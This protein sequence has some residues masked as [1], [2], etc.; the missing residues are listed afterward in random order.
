MKLQKRLNRRVAGKDYS[1]WIVTIPPSQVSQLGWQEGENL[2]AEIRGG[3]LVL[4]RSSGQAPNR[5]G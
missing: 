4:R 3:S 1:K 2:E 5:D